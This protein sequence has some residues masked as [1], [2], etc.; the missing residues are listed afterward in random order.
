MGG[1]FSYV[2]GYASIACS[3]Q[4][5]IVTT[6]SMKVAVLG[7]HQAGPLSSR[8]VVVSTLIQSNIINCTGFVQSVYEHLHACLHYASCIHL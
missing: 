8:N 5:W 6:A 7:R 2:G 4:T 3:V 1:W